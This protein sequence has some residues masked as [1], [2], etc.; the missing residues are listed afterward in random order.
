MSEI[1]VRHDDYLVARSALPMCV[2]KTR[3]RLAGMIACK[4]AGN[5][6]ILAPASLSKRTGHARPN[7]TVFDALFEVEH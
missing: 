2:A 7:I 4:S 3:A 1:L 6:P 5:A